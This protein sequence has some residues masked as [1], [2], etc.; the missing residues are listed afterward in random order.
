M[1]IVATPEAVEHVRAGGGELY[2]WA[3][4]MEYGYHPVF[5]LEA[6]FEAP[7]P[8]GDFHRFE[9]EGIVLLFDPGPRELPESVHLDMSGR[10]RKRI[11]ASWNGHSFTPG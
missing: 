8:A 5:V 3:V 7:G 4:T 11:R 10:V 2:V 6:S 1:R 9:G